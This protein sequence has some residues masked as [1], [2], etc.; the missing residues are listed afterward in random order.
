MWNLSRIGTESFEFCILHV[1][2]ELCACPKTMEDIP[3]G[4]SSAVYTG[5]QKG[6]KRMW[7]QKDVIAK[8]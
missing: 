8:G 6:S 2:Y 1:R 5:L 4:L 3:N 7:L